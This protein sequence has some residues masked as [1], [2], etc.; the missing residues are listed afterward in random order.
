[1][2]I[3]LHKLQ[4]QGFAVLLA[5]YQD[6]DTSPGAESL[7]R[8]R[9]R[10]EYSD[11]VDQY[12]IQL[13]AEKVGYVR[14]QRRGNDV[15][16]LSQ[17]FILSAFQERGYAQQAIR[18]AERQYPQARAWELDTIKQ[19]SKLCHLYEKMGYRLAGS[20]HCIRDG[21]DL[22]DYVKP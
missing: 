19:E 6:F 9:E 10:F 21:M 22:V 11:W 14:I 8:V 1:M 7:E 16:R 15:Y 20:E 4:V 3:E 18:Q 17:M 13:G 12:W 5:K 2:N